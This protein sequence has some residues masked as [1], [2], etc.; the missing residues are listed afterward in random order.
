MTRSVAALI[1]LAFGPLDLHRFQ[2]L[3]ATGNRRSRAV[4]ERLRLRHEGTMRDAE[5][6]GERFV[7][8]EVYAVLAPE[9]RGAAPPRGGP[10]AAAS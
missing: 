10:P 1:D 8:L 7:D 5:R 6:I 9:W 3:A 2:L 4:A